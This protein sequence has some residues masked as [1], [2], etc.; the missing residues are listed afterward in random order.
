[1]I[2]VWVDHDMIRTYKK[3]VPVHHSSEGRE[4]GK[5][6]A[7]ALQKVGEVFLSTRIVVKK[8]TK[9]PGILWCEGG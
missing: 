2:V 6:N 3:K 9:A 8:M 7:Q 1:M 5:Q 4:C